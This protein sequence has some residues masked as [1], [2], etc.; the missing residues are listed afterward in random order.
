MHAPVAIISALIVR[1]PSLIAVTYG[2]IIFLRWSHL[3]GSSPQDVS[4]P[5]NHLL[6]EVASLHNWWVEGRPGR[7][8]GVEYMLDL[9][10]G[11]HMKHDQPLLLGTHRHRKGQQALWASCVQELVYRMGER[12]YHELEQHAC[13]HTQRRLLN[14]IITYLIPLITY[15][16]TY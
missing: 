13:T 4:H 16:T 11:A 5:G 7:N 12:R 1:A 14:L 10:L 3:K 8:N 15:Y 2:V 6:W 9:H